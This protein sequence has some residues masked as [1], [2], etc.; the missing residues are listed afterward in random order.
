VKDDGP[1]CRLG[2][3]PGR[4][5]REEKA[6]S[7]RH[8]T[9]K[10][11]ELMGSAVV[12]G[13]K[14]MGRR[15]ARQGPNDTRLRREAPA[16]DG[17]E[18]KAFDCG[19]CRGPLTLPAEASPTVLD[20]PAEASRLS[21]STFSRCTV[22]KARPRSFTPRRFHVRAPPGEA[23]MIL[24]PRDRAAAPSRRNRPR[25]PSEF[26]ISVNVVRVVDA[27]RVPFFFAGVLRR[28]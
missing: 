27:K 18:E 24:A 19:I 5:G 14:G 6:A 25:A 17:R 15:V 26:Q 8:R 3:Y 22:S 23:R 2:P 4:R 21:P 12:C 10:T 13:Q 1:Q 7:A 28:F 16:L 9:G 11:E 20:T